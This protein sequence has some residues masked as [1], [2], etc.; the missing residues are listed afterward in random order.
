MEAAERPTKMRKLNADAEPTAVPQ[1][2]R[3]PDQPLL[4]GVEVNGAVVPSTETAN[5]SKPADEAASH[6]ADVANGQENV[7][8]EDS[9]TEEH[10]QNQ[11][12]EQDQESK[13]TSTD[14]AQQDGQPLSKNQLKKLRKKQEWEAGREYRKLKRKQKMQEKR[15]R[16][17]EAREGGGEQNPTSDAGTV[18]QQNQRKKPRKPVQLPITIIIDCGFDGLMIEK[19]RISLGSQIT[20]SYSDNSR[21]PFQ[22]HLVISSWG[23]HLK[24][25]FDTVLNKHY[26]NW[27]GVTFLEEDFVEAARRADE[28]MKGPRGGKLVGV[29]EK[30]AAAAAGVQSNR[31]E[32]RQQAEHVD[33]RQTHP[34]LES[35]T[36]KPA[37]TE[38]EAEGDPAAAVDS[39]VTED[40][41]A[42]PPPTSS[43]SLQ[44]DSH[45]TSQQDPAL[46]SAQKDTQPSTDS[47][48]PAPTDLPPQHHHPPIPKGEVVYLTS[49][50][51]DTLTELS[52]YSTYIVGGLVDK[53]RHKGICYKIA[54]ER[55]IKTAKLP[56]GEYME[57][58]SR[59][60][61][62]TNHVV[63]IMVRWLECGD[64]GEAFLKVIPKRKGGRLRG[65]HDERTVDSSVAGDEERE[66]EDDHEDEDVDHDNDNRNGAAADGA[67]HGNEA[68]ELEPQ[69]E[70]QD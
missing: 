67:N 49:D 69:V 68:T 35:D 53:N 36:S 22:A 55:G 62:A 33:Q 19:E 9:E 47:T 6:N 12:E 24:K 5:G 66:D 14:P 23:G 45:Q 61:L 64:W 4:S 28:I 31:L 56:I 37:E 34:N 41:I 15:A 2:T 46:E 17:R 26:L 52:P 16:K 13:T 3:T 1:D 63:E 51:P 40:T 11:N 39:K 58:Q 7:E 60:V 65:D 18:Q 59:K 44:D 25:R 38:H 30:Y 10:S 57:M 70:N 50:S 21:A 20:R 42:N 8:R 29:F 32:D 43:S 48:T 54:R 27:R